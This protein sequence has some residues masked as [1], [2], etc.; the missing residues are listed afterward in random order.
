MPERRG[1]ALVTGGSRGIGAATVRALVADGWAVGVGYRSDAD[2]AEA[3]VGQVAADGGQALA[4]A[5]D[6]ADREAPDA[7]IGA[8]EER[9]GPVLVLVNNAGVRADGLAP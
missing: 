8:L 7:L 3:V 2:A 1:C 4:V 9:F 6:V 5:G